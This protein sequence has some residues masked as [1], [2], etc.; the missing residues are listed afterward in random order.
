M[1][2]YIPVRDIHPEHKL[3]IFTCLIKLSDAKL[4]ERLAGFEQST[5]KGISS[6]GM[7]EIAR[8]YWEFKAG[9]TKEVFPYQVSS[10]MRVKGLYKAYHA[11]APDANEPSGDR[12]LKYINYRS[13]ENEYNL[14]G[15]LWDKNKIQEITDRWIRLR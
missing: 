2:L 1:L 10:D 11:N 8:K 5:P 3:D 12:M 7:N 6:W 14:S 4:Y 15:L 13:A 9:I